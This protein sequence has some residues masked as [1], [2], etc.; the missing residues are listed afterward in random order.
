MIDLWLE[1]YG[2]H[3]VHLKI[4]IVEQVLHEVVDDIGLI[5]LTQ[6]RH[7][8]GIARIDQAEECIQRVDGNHHNYPYNMF[9]QKLCQHTGV[10]LDQRKR[11]S[12]LMA[13]HLKK[14]LIE[15]FEM[16]YEVK[17]ADGQCTE[18]KQ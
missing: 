15:M 5:D 3:K 1:L 17:E 12:I 13:S 7:V 9:L 8:E 2:D 10:L 14:W 4:Q 11:S 16:L 18:D 6:R